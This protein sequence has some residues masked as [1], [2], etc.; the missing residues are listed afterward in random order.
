MALY[1]NGEYM[2]CDMTGRVGKLAAV[3]E[4]QGQAN[5]EKKPCPTTAVVRHRQRGDRLAPVEAVPQVLRPRTYKPPVAE[6]AP[7]VGLVGGVPG[8]AS[9]GEPSEPPSPPHPKKLNKESSDQD[10]YSFDVASLG[11]EEGEVVRASFSDEEFLTIIRAAIWK[12]VTDTKAQLLEEKKVQAA[13]LRTGH[14]DRPVAYANTMYKSKARKINPHDDVIPSGETPPGSYKWKEEVLAEKVKHV[15]DE[16]KSR[17]DGI[18]ADIHP[19]MA[20]QPRGTRLTAERIKDIMRGLEDTELTDQEK[21]AL[22]EVLFRREMA[23]SWDFSEIGRLD[24]RV[25]PPYE[26]KTVPHKAWQAK[27]IPVPGALKEA[28]VEVLRARMTNSVL[29]ESVSPYRNA[30]FLVEKPSGGLRLIN[31][32]TKLNGCDKG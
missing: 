24:E 2:M 32:A 11:L 4:E 29:E 16:S 14:S 13:T 6:D 12:V 5:G 10:E 9:K 23:M 1:Y 27:G 30:W 28:V 21:A 31:S 17:R 22:L 7:A 3:C 26:M 19:R 8:T 25:A 15:E 18:W 20:Q